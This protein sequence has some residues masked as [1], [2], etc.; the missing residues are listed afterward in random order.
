MKTAFIFG[1]FI[2][3]AITMAAS[4]AYANDSMARVGAGGIRLIKSEHIRMLEEVLEISTRKVSVKYRFLNESDHDIRTTVAFPMPPYHWTGGQVWLD[5]NQKPVS[6]FKAFVDGRPVSTKTVTKA[7][8]GDVDVTQRLRRAGLSDAKI[9][10]FA[11][12]REGPEKIV[13]DFTQK[14][15]KMVKRLNGGEE[16]CPPW[17]VASTLVWEQRFPAHK[18]VVVEHR[19]APF[20]GILYDAPYQKR[21]GYRLDSACPV[22]GA[23]AGTDEA[24]LDA[25]FRKI[26]DDRIKALAAGGADMVYVTLHDV[27][28]ILGT[29]RNWKGPIGVF[30]LRIKKDSPDQLVS[31]CLPGEL[32]KVDSTSY[33]FTQKDFVPQD[34]LVVY[35]YDVGPD[36]AYEVGRQN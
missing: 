31:L 10:T 6:T 35:F 7:L 8:V 29:G 18:E 22:A 17:T 28:Y 5:E 11:G 19:Y 23:A 16:S 33:E 9:R 24:C 36:V 15:K 30:T 14:Q 25:A 26:V 27:E 1:F 13:S 32:K 4:A 3:A 12:C 21:F 34:R 20:F 2:A